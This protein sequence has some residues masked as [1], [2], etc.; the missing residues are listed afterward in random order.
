[1]DRKGSHDAESPIGWLLPQHR[2]RG[3]AALNIHR[4]GHESTK[5]MIVPEHTPLPSP[6]LP[7]SSILYREVLEAQVCGQ[8]MNLRVFQLTGRESVTSIIELTPPCF[9]FA[10]C[11]A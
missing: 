1:M 9:D 5:R 6:L 2:G 11:L 10:K 4:P 3:Q 8:F 7:P